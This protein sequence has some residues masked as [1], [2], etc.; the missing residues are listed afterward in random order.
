MIPAKLLDRVASSVAVPRDLHNASQSTLTRA[1]GTAAQLS[2]THISV[3]SFLPL[4]T[5]SDQPQGYLP[6][7]VVVPYT[8]PLQP[9]SLPG[10]A[11]SSERSVTSSIFA[12]FV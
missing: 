12:D 5:P 2:L 8:Q 11:P 3:C 9:R 7:G 6:E 10:A 1:A 4:K